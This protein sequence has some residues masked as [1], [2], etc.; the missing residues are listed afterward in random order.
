MSTGTIRLHRVLRAPPERVY[1]AFLDADAVAKTTRSLDFGTNV[2]G[3]TSSSNEKA[4][5]GGK[6]R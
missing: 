5:A 1:R 3:S 6:P 2:E 4:V